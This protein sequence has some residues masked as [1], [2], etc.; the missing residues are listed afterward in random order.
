MNGWMH[1]LI[2]G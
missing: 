1:A 2:D